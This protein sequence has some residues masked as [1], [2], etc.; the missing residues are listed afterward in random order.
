M[1][2]TSSNLRLVSGFIISS[3]LLRVAFNYHSL[4]HAAACRNAMGVSTDESVKCR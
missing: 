1:I 2:K 4:K 3:E